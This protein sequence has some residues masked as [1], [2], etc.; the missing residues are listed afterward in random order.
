MDD[1]TK[2]RQLEAL[3]MIVLHLHGIRWALIAIA[4]NI[5]VG[6]LMLRNS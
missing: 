2:R 5:A 6:F 3:E 4:F 1:I